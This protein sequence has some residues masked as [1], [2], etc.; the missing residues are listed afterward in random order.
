[1]ISCFEVRY[2]GE[3]ADMEQIRE[4]YRVDDYIEAVEERDRAI[5]ERDED[6]VQN[7]PVAE[8]EMFPRL[9]RILDKVQERLGISFPCEVR[10]AKVR[11]SQI[12]MV[13]RETGPDDLLLQFVISPEIIATHDDDELAFMFGYSLGWEIW[14]FARFSSLERW[15]GAV[16]R[17]HYAEGESVLPGMG[18]ALYKRWSLKA[19][20]SADRMGAIAAG[21]FEPSVKA[22]LRGDAMQV[23]GDDK[24]QLM[25]LRTS[26][27]CIPGIRQ[28]REF[29]S[30]RGETTPN[31]GVVFRVR[32]LCLFCE[33]WLSS[34]N[35]D[36]DLKTVDEILD[37]D[38]SK[39]ARRVGTKEERESVMAFLAQAILM[40]THNGRKPSMA[41]MRAVVSKLYDDNTDNP[42]ELFE[43]G[44]KRIVDEGSRVC[45]RIARQKSVDM[46]LILYKDLCSVAAVDGRDSNEKNLYLEKI[47]KGLGI[48]DKTAAALRLIAPG[49]VGGYIVDPLADELVASVKAKFEGRR[50]NDSASR[51]VAS[52]DASAL[53][54][55][56]GDIDGECILRDIYHA[57]ALVKS[58][59]SFSTMCLED[60]GR[61]E[62]LKGGI[63]LTRNTSPRVY[64][65]VRRVADRLGIDIPFEVF[66]KND[67]AINA[68]ARYCYRRGKAHGIVLVSSGAMESLDNNELAFVVGHELG[69]LMHG[70]SRWGALEKEVEQGAAPETVLP[71]MGEIA[72]RK[73]QQKQEIS[74]DRAGVVA[75]GSAAAA[76]SALVKICYG[77]S[78]ANFNADGVDELLGQIREVKDA[79]AIE[80]S[81]FET[82][83]IEPLRIKALRIF[84]EAYYSNELDDRRL[85]EIDNEIASYYRW[86]RRYPR[87]D[88]ELAVMHAFADGG[89]E[90][91]LA[92]GSLDE[93]EIGRMCFV[94]NCCTDEPESEFVLDAKRRRARLNSAVRILRREEDASLNGNLLGQLVVL[95]LSDGPISKQEHRYL[96]KL[97]KRIGYDMADA[98]KLIS[99]KVAEVGFP[100]DALLDQHINIFEKVLQERS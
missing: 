63:R 85:R 27:M 69:H 5:G 17:D 19:M 9:Y 76:V 97:A 70:H 31:D 84:G 3:V 50:T 4:A 48:D 47:A 16:E 26:D 96:L 73:W 35:G 10:L 40:L 98:H 45:R 25:P 42:S 90:M 6:F 7:I 82:H 54:R 83:P 18:N 95:A 80:G 59:A 36:A 55:Y 100:I 49:E 52:G 72:Y 75:A 89:I 37:N 29:E 88:S 58:C 53:Y 8:P 13:A 34:Q 15:R 94:L 43:C 33:K 87:K 23:A 60:A 11:L 39:V 56:G 28:F 79:E 68:S 65:I 20:I 30:R 62:A 77:L 57:D 99:D 32:A 24:A 61:V 91:L 46:A 21:G 51:V 81:V 12:R 86:I 67:S 64:G 41:E 66:C 2:R 78:G 38:F 71:Q 74:A 1:M 22:L 44:I 93:R 92:D 14:G